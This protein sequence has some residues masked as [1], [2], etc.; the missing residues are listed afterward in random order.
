MKRLAL[1][2]LV[3]FVFI[4]CSSAS[5]IGEDVAGDVTGTGTDQNGSGAGD[6]DAYD[7][8]GDGSGPV[9]D[10]KPRPRP[11]E[12]GAPCTSNSDCESGYCIEGLDG[13]ICTKLCMEDCPQGYECV[14]V[15]I[16]SD[17][18][19]ICVP[20]VD[21][22]CE[23][24]SSDL[25]CSGGRCVDFGNG[26]YCLAPCKTAQCKKSYQCQ[27]VQLENSVE[28]LCMPSSAT[29]ECVEAS[30]GQ[31]KTCKRKAGSN[32]CYGVQFCEENGWGE[33]LLSEEV[34]DGKDNDCNGTIDDGFINVQTN[35]YD[36]DE[37]C[38]IC[39][40]NC[41]AMTATRSFGKCNSSGPIP[42]CV[43]ACEEGFHDVNNNPTDG[44]ECEYLSDSDDPDEA[45]DSNCDGIDG[46]IP[47]GVF[48]AKNGDDANSGSMD[49]PV[50]SVQQGI[51]LAAELA[52]PNVYVA[53]GVYSE[54]VELLT[55]ANAYGGYSADFEERAPGLNQTVIMGLPSAPGKPG[56]V[57][58]FDILDIPTTM[59]GFHIFGGDAMA[60]GGSSYAVYV[61]NSNN[62][63][64]FV[65]NWIIAGNGRD[66]PHGFDG[67]DGGDG[68]DGIAGLEAYDIMHE[69]C[70]GAD[71]NDGGSGGKHLCDGMP[72]DGGDGG[73]GVCPDYDESGS[74]PKSSPYDQSHAASEWGQDGKGSGA[75]I[76]GEPGYDGLLWNEYSNCGVC[77]MPKSPDSGLFLPTLGADGSDGADGA[78]GTGAGG[79][80]TPEGDVVGDLWAGV[81]GSWGDDGK[82]SSGGAGGGAGGGVETID[83]SGK[84]LI[85][86]TDVGGSGGGGGSGAC[87]GTA[88]EG[89]DSG[90]G[91]FALFIVGDSQ[92][93]SIPVLT[94]N[95][96]Q[97]GFGGD[98]G[99][100]GAGGVG[101]EG[102]KG[103]GGGYSGESQ[104]SAW[105]ADAGGH[106]GNG[107][108]GGHGG[109]GGGGCGGP[110]FG[111]FLW[112]PGPNL[113]SAYLE[114]NE[115]VLSGDSGEGGTGGKS[116]GNPGT[117]GQ[118]GAAGNTSF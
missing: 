27:N 40:N 16:G 39:G 18:V 53:T 75:G 41:T 11:G 52:R 88:G 4:A 8:L 105:C 118:K 98:G 6:T 44:C 58:C 78:N 86:Y 7:P 14:G 97:T 15:N 56:A 46:V 5:T 24:C 106:G 3:S 29:C 94:G 70:T 55:G 93:A 107:G 100:G 114:E 21:R 17:V 63:L 81:P 71:W 61:Y 25:H 48:V 19:F 110:S 1:F 104:G 45:G 59:S 32:I 33:C 89:G 38:G 113:A 30:I 36:T 23:P 80:V 69:G 68:A 103:E 12:F 102:G 83:C 73:S 91:S 62:G 109:G 2:V 115:F 116:M 10:H 99:D 64:R 85:K 28:E 111:I 82:S 43:W 84:P 20:L 87:K 37:H 42:I 34:C 79:C 49:E 74:Q 67:I 72:V 65:N 96:L 66:G 50:L 112:G 13:Y 108:R 9:D 76:G 47:D 90:G 117:S 57:N 101:G 60:D 51:D 26:Q 92:A 22:S 77:N 31:E 54:S 95:T 35:K